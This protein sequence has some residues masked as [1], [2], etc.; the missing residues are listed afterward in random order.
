MN[1]T[2]N[3]IPANWFKELRF[4]S[5][6]PH[7]NAILI[8]SDIV[9]WYR[10]TEIRD[11]HSGAFLGYRKKFKSDKLQRSYGA[12][13][14]LFG[15]TKRQVKDAMDYLEDEKKLITREFRTVDT[16]AGRLN[17]VLYI[18]LNVEELRKVT[19]AA[20]YPLLRSNVG[21]SYAGTDHPPTFERGTNTEITTKI[22]EDRLI[23]SYNA[24]GNNTHSQP[25]EQKSDGMPPS[26]PGSA[27]VEISLPDTLSRIEELFTTLCGKFM[28][29]KDYKVAVSLIK[30]RIP[31][32]TIL[33]GMSQAAENK[34]KS[35]PQSWNEIKSLAYFAKPIQQL[36]SE[37]MAKEHALK[38]LANMPD[39]RGAQPEVATA[40][41]PTQQAQLNP[42]VDAELAALMAEMGGDNT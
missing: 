18:D 19:Y 24:Q 20:T 2:G 7:V 39:L 22:L 16:E 28:S 29:D 23:D 26:V 4:P 37:R 11:E 5:G 8:L 12:I 42:N 33:D 32:Q 15:L 14:E 25:I 30:S 41:E 21:G 9:Y 34:K 38:E 13:G 1:W 17:N 10:P 27:Q 6:K 31:P 3:I 40:A 36:H 35:D